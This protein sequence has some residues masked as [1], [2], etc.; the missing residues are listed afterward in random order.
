MLEYGLQRIV[1]R[2]EALAMSLEAAGTRLGHNNS[3]R[4]ELL[5]RQLVEL[6]NGR[7]YREGEGKGWQS[8]I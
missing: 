3:T 7:A 8:V 4:V 5:L 2:R 6:L 1:Y